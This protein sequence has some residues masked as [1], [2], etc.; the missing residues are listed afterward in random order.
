MPKE[1]IYTPPTKTGANQIAARINWSKQEEG[2]FVQIAVFED[3]GTYEAE[4]EKPIYMDMDRDAINRTI[5]VLR[6]ARDQA[7][8]RD[9]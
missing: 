6:R 9:E 1:Y 7:Y 4:H 5:R 2:G 8:G 3:D